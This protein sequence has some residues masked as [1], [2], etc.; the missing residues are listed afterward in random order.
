M[1]A[2]FGTAP[3]DS[4]LSKSQSQAVSFASLLARRCI[5]L[6]WKD[7]LPPSHSQW[8]K[9]VMA[10]LK[11]EELRFRIG[12]SSRNYHKVWQPFIDYFRSL[13]SAILTS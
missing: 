4:P 10:H 13:S 1:T 6:K 11:L 12:G 2:I 9:D 7:G 3:E 5:L 8:V